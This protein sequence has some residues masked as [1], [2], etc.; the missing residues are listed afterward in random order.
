M[1]TICKRYT[2]EDFS[3]HDCLQDSLMQVLTHIDKF[4]ETG[5]FKSWIARITVTK[6]LEYLRKNKKH[7]SAEIGPTDEPS[8]DEVISYKLEL[9]D[10][11]KFLDTLPYNARVAINMYLVEGYSHREIGEQLG[12]NESS[13]RSLVARTRKLIKEKFES[14][15]LSIVHHKKVKKDNT[16]VHFTTRNEGLY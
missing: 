12:V 4:H 8:Q 10:V 13:S 11:T 6:C 2:R 3:A 14:E 1:F 16:D 5:K 15:Y 9:E 7:L